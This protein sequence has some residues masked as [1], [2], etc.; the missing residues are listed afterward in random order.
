MP[1]PQH[2][3]YFY[4]M[5]TI[6]VP[7]DFSGPAH[8]ATNYAAEIALQ[9]GANLVLLNVFSPNVAAEGVTNGNFVE[10]AERYSE[11]HLH[12]L[13]QKLVSNGFVHDVTC[14]SR[15]GIAQE[16]IEETTEVVGAD[17]IVMGITGEAGAIKEKIIGSTTLDI[18]RKLQTPLFIVPEGAPLG[19]VKK[20]SFACD[21]FN[22]Q[23]SSGTE[24][25]KR[26]CQ[27]FNAELEVVNVERRSVEDPPIRTRN[28]NF[29]ETLLTNVKHR[30]V[31]LNGDEGS[32]ETLR[33]YF[34]NH[35]TDLIVLNPKK[36]NFLQAPFH[37]SMTRAMAFRSKVPL[38]IV[39]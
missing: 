24:S 19:T 28:L 9:T 25:V 12:E 8:Y 23:G 22:L 21:I 7:T 37:K 35:P 14:I 5:K 1:V 27:L 10:E 26:F 4:G 38:L 15:I 17:A 32:E 34:D 36:Q 29:L 11:K 31:V 2:T 18:A 6:L 20:M 13:K 39:H 16:V 33:N 3:G 30:L